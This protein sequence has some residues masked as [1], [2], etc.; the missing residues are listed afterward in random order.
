M[1]DKEFQVFLTLDDQDLTGKL[2]LAGKDTLLTVH[3]KDPIVKLPE[4][5]E[6]ICQDGQK[7]SLLNCL[8]FGG[9]RS[10]YHKEVI[11][12]AQA[13]PHIVVLGPHHCTADESSVASFSFHL[14][15]AEQLFFHLEPWIQGD[16]Y[17]FSDDQQSYTQ[18][19]SFTEPSVIF[20]AVSAVGKVSAYHA[21]S[22]TGPS[23][24]GFSAENRVMVSIESG[25]PIS[26]NE[27]IELIYKFKYFSE[28][29]SGRPQSIDNISFVSSEQADEGH[30][31][32]LDLIISHSEDDSG[33]DRYASGYDMLAAPC[34]DRSDFEA[35]VISWFN[36]D[37]Y[38]RRVALSRFSS[39]LKSD[40]HYDSN[41]LVSAAS[42]FEWFDSSRKVEVPENIVSFIEQTK[43]TLLALPESDM[44]NRFLNMLG[45]AGSETLQLKIRRQLEGVLSV[46]DGYDS[47]DKRK[48]EQV[49]AYAVKCRNALVH[50]VRDRKVGRV[51]EAH[52]IFLIETLEV[53]FACL[54]LHTAGWSIRRQD[55]RHLR[56]STRY[57]GFLHEFNT[58]A[59][60][61]FADADR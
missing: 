43:A 48:A 49:I 39:N 27:L 47:F 13:F 10:M 19:F 21:P 23:M 28:V 37:D 17:E 11:Y 40:N 1:S 33:Q 42:L 59:E 26:I 14:S 8:S 9:G 30:P 4:Y 2:V 7:A 45:N 61:L 32:I 51:L 6:C 3:A 15:D 35:L 16:H 58:R 25:R 29:C 44:Q 54:C 55:D 46:L 56:G 24:S 52:Q 50:G 5:V 31:V 18:T 34:L 41:R 57:C 20:E 12:R 38:R 22:F 53:L 60:Q 36:E